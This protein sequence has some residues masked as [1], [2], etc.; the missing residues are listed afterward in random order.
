MNVILDALGLAAII[1]DPAS[2]KKATTAVING[3][4]NNRIDVGV[5]VLLSGNTDV[6]SV[7]LNF[8]FFFGG[9]AVLP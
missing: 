4:N 9:A 5:H 6:K 1:S 3:S 7:D 8:G 2:A